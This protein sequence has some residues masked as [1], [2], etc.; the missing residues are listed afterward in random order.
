[1]T[2]KKKGDKRHEQAITDENLHQILTR[3]KGF[4]NDV[5]YPQLSS[6]VNQIIYRFS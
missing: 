4:Y 1:M 6:G 2:G 5:V 3:T